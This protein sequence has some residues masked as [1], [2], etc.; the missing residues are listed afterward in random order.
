MFFPHQY[1]QLVASLV[2]SVALVDSPSPDPDHVHVGL[3]EESNLK[4]SFFF[5]V[6]L[7]LFVYFAWCSS[8]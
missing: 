4:Y 7:Q 3:P 2:E 8:W 1:P 5:L 6:F